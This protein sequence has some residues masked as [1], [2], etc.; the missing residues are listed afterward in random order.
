M[1][2]LHFFGGSL[3]MM[4]ENFGIIIRSWFRLVIDSTLR[5]LTGIKISFLRNLIFYLQNVKE[6]IDKIFFHLIAEH[7]FFPRYA[8]WFETHEK[9]LKISSY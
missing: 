5:C 2:L 1:E 6:E 7:D 3:S 8:K 9:V 4:C